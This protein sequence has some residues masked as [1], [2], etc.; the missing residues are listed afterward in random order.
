MDKAVE[1]EVRGN[2]AVQNLSAYLVSFFN[3]I[4]RWDPRV[5]DTILDHYHC[6]V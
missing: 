4:V 2:G 1:A 5:K 3:S 6:C